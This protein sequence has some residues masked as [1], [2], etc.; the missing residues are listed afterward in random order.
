MIIKCDFILSGSCFCEKYN[1]TSFKAEYSSY[2]RLWT[3]SCYELY[4]W[5]NIMCIT[6]QWKVLEIH[7]PN[8][9]FK[10][11]STKN[12]SYR[13]RKNDSLPQQNFN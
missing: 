2:F 10:S 11:L 6:K 1:N 12:I 4:V 13:H 5:I 3:I 9:C 7:S 8:F